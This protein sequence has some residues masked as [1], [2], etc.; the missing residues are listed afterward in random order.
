MCRGYIISAVRFEV[1]V[2]GCKIIVITDFIQS[3][4][5][6]LTV[7]I[8]I[9]NSIFFNYSVEHLTVRAEFVVADRKIT[10]CTA[11]IICT[12]CLDHTAPIG[13]VI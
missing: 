3:V 1:P 7:D 4:G 5:S 12:V 6:L 8:Q 2:G 11:Y 13:V 9:L 10:I